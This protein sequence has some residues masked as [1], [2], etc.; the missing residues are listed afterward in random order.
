MTPSK[1]RDRP[2]PHFCFSWNSLKQAP[3]LAR[4]SRKPC[5]WR[6]GTAELMDARAYRPLTLEAKACLRAL[7]SR[8]VQG[9][10]S[11][12]H[13]RGPQPASPQT[14]PP[15]VALSGHGGSFAPPGSL[16]GLST[17]AGVRKRHQTQ[18]TLHKKE[19]GQT[20]A[21]RSI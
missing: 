21:L 6:T 9:R 16:C 12:T 20:A 4:R 17:W 19:N 13:P 14:A 8:R 18:H 5:V 3:G 15:E 10:S 1:S 11:G 2:W 7:P